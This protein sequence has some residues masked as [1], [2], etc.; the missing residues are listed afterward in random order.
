[1]T[2]GW[3]WRRTRS[4]RSGWYSVA[5]AQGLPEAQFDLGVLYSSGRVAPKND[6]EALTWYRRAADQGFA[7]AQYTL[8][9]LYEDGTGVM[10]DY[11][12]AMRWYRLAAAQGH[13]GAQ[14]NLGRF[15]A[16][17]LGV[18]K[19]N[20]KVLMWYNLALPGL[21]GEDAGSALVFRDE[22]AA[23]MTEQQVA[24]ATELATRCRDSGFKTCE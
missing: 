7:E 19:D 15:Y 8:G 20:V 18:P 24:Q 12:E 17:G 10:R 14:N 21:R 2:K 16:D 9:N 3:G 1:M 22:L 6:A 4:P 23:E 5:A 13:P 11:T